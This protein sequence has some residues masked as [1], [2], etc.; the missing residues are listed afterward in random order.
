MTDRDIHASTD[1][2][3]GEAQVRPALFAEMHFKGQVLRLWSGVGEYT[4]ADHVWQ[5]TGILGSVG[6]VEETTALEAAGI[7]LQLS[8]VPTEALALA[9]TEY[10]QGRR[11][12]L[13]LAFLDRAG[14]IVGE[15]VGPWGYL[16]DRIEFEEGAD[17]SVLALHCEN[18]LI[19]LDRS[20]DRRS[21]HED[22]RLDYP[23]DAGYEYVAG[24][25]DKQLS[26]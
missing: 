21:T 20:S 14:A 1:A 16:M 11:A 23:D 7:S 9:M 18:R 15:P 10:P 26:W 22:Q 25:Q 5:G 2:E 13:W 19:A 12:N 17:S 6:T 4:W 24:L 3:I 8:G